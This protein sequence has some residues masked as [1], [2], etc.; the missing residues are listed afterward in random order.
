MQRLSAGGLSGTSAD[1]R[2]IMKIAIEQ[3]ASSIV[4][5]HNH[6]SGNT[7]PSNLDINLTQKVKDGGALLNIRLMDHVI[8]AENKYYSFAEEGRL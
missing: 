5:C 4:L 8:V 2:F 1:V 6:P 3:L 7:T